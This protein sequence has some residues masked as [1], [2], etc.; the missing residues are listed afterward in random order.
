MPVNPS[1]C[2]EQLSALAQKDRFLSR[3]DQRPL[4][5]SMLQKMDS[6][7]RAALDQA[8]RQ[9]AETGQNLD[10]ELTEAGDLL[11][12]ANEQL[13][14]E[15]AAALATKPLSQETLSELARSIEG[16][17]LWLYDRVRSRLERSLRRVGLKKPVPGDILQP[18]TAAWSK[19]CSE[20]PE[21]LVLIVDRQQQHQTAG[22]SI[23]EIEGERLLEQAC[24]GHGFLTR[25][26]IYLRLR[27]QLRRRYR[28]LHSEPC[29]TLK[30][31]QPALLQK[32]PL[33]ALEN[34][35]QQH[36]EMIR[37]FADLWR[38]L[39]FNL[40]TAAEDCSRLATDLSNPDPNPAADQQLAE[41]T[42]LVA[43]TLERAAGQLLTIA[44]PLKEAWQQLLTELDRDR[45][46]I[47]TLIPRDLQ[48]DLSLRERVMH[49]QR[50]LD[51][52]WHRWREQGRQRLDKPLQLIATWWDKM[53][54]LGR[55]LL[56]KP[57]SDRGREE[58]LQQL[59]DLPTATDILS[60]AASLPPVCRRLFTM[61]ALKNRE[62]L[63]GK[64][65]DLETLRELFRRWQE[66]RLCSVA[67]V[68]PHGSGKSSLVNCFQSE[69]DH[70]TTIH[71]LTIDTRLGST[72]Q[73]LE[74][75]TNWFKLPA[76]PADLD[77]LEKQLN[78]LPPA[79]VIVNNA[80]RLLLRTPGGL[81]TA[82]TF[83]RLVLATRRR[84]L[85]IITCRK[86]PWQRM[87]HLLQID[88]YFTH[89]L[90]TLFGTQ[91][92]MRDA[93]LLRLQTSS[94]P[95]VF[96]ENT[97]AGN[98]TIKNGNGT[99][100]NSLQERFFVDLFAASRGNMQAA[101]YYWLLC[102][103]YDQTQETLT[104]QPLGK[105]DHSSLRSLDRQQL[106]ALAEIVAHGELTTAEHSAIFSCDTLRSHM[107]LDHLTQL[108]LLECAPEENTPDRY[109]LNPLFF[110][111]VTA[112]LE[113]RNILL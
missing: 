68:G 35:Q 46:E 89:Q 26:L 3:T 104:V 77:A 90:Q 31:H 76:I 85:W 4:L 42:R 41:T 102:L 38:N 55:R 93:L 61:G 16:R 83:L 94:Y 109:Q 69:L 71:H 50:R 13:G 47:L 22:R 70:Q 1:D 37:A 97:T 80:H 113:G 32:K 39:R 78:Q 43:D 91:V 86:Y 75:C 108:N 79:V 45:E 6:A 57:G 81:E 10:H 49:S 65:M 48:R 8:N 105:L 7:V 107:L 51:R 60:R 23:W 106:Y 29:D 59:S 14:E 64:E 66:G 24:N 17:I 67:V 2:R 15:F 95:V 34:C 9:L 101:L 110:A 53:P 52:S 82:R 63:I 40:E 73:L 44:A 30:R 5:D 112:T 54:S 11:R 33:P 98:Q 12:K 72:A 18:L 84:L 19:P 20:M 96:Q 103:S 99:D 28:V 111:P 62:F 87:Q 58:T 100:Q 88:R 27:Q 56:S 74:L 21:E 25:R 92:E 36:E